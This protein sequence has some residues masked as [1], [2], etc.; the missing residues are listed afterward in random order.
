MVKKR[1]LDG[2]LTVF[3]VVVSVPLASCQNKE[4]EGCSNSEIKTEKPSQGKLKLS[5][6][7][8][9]IK[10][11][12]GIII[13]D[14][15]SVTCKEFKDFCRKLK[16]ALKKE[17]LVTGFDDISLKPGHYDMF[18]FFRKADKYVYWSYRV[19]RYDTPTDLKR[20]DYMHG[21]LYRTAENEKDYKGGH[22]RYTSLEK[23]CKD[24]YT[25][26]T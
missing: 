3:D 23:L 17:A 24:A 5:P 13:E 1:L 19:E 15:L 18:G 25:L 26:I 20:S 12:D 22:N 2:Q 11:Y 4:L 8:K 21:V 9:F 16:S 10:E 14:Q 7:Q 6:I